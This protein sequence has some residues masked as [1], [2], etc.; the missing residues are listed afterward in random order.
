MTLADAL[1]PVLARLR[2]RFAQTPL[3][4]F[5]RWWTGELLSFLPLRWREVLTVEDACVVLQADGE[6]FAVS[7]ERGGLRRPLMLLAA[8]EREEWAQLLERGLDDSRRGQRRVLMLPASRL[9]RRTLSLPAAALENLDAVLGFELDRQTP[10]KADQVYFDSRILRQDPGAKQVQ[11]ELLVVPKPVL[12]TELNQLGSIAAGLSAVDVV[13]THGSR[14]GVNLLPPSARASMPRAHPII[15]SSLFAVSVLLVLFGMGQVTENRLG[16]VASMQAEVEVQ[17]ENARVVVALRKQLED[18]AAAANFLAV[19]KQ[20]Q[21]S[22]LQLL[23]EITRTLPDDTFLERLSVSDN[24]VSITGFSAQA[25][26]LV[27]FLQ[28]SPLLRDA[29]LNGSIQPDP[30][31]A[32]DRVTITVNYGPPAEVKP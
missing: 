32:R 20:T 24:Q 11:V 23:S 22:M 28:E 26:R 18:A 8:G 27:G 16:A 19:Q 29:A 10:F 1:N 15:Q 17:R 30:R 7:A 5:W 2:S 31:V 3:P 21:A 12:D 13:D 9:L 14:L 4:R 6:N 25:T